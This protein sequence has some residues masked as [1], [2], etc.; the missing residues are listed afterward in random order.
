M[1]YEV[2]TVATLDD[3]LLRAAESMGFSDALTAPEPTKPSEAE[4]EADPVPAVAQA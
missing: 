1:L 4:S 3:D 2:I